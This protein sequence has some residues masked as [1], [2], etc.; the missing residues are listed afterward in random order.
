[1]LTF[2]IPG[3]KSR[4]GPRETSTSPRRSARRRLI[5]R[6][7]ECSRGRRHLKV[8]GNGLKG[9]GTVLSE[10]GSAVTFGGGAI[11]GAVARC[12]FRKAP[13]RPWQGHTSGRRW[14]TCAFTCGA[15]ETFFA[16]SV[17]RGTTCA[18]FLEGCRGQRDHG[19][20]VGFSGNS[21]S[22]AAEAAAILDGIP[23]LPNSLNPT[24]NS[25]STSD[26]DA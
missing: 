19:R 4:S 6:T 20:C 22:N 26:L 8:Q 15:V 11:G 2:E 3:S 14:P 9:N 16:H 25:D 7:G 18:T 10:N 23:M 21:A 12:F 5:S 17:R 24:R 13:N 1:M